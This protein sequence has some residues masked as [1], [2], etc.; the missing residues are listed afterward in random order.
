MTARKFTLYDCEANDGTKGWFVLKL[1]DGEHEGVEE[2][3]PYEDDPN[4]MYLYCSY[5]IGTACVEGT[6]AEFKA[7]SDAIRTG[8]SAEFRRCAA[9]RLEDGS[10]EI[11]S[12]R[13]E[14]EPYPVVSPEEA[15]NIVEAISE[16]IV[17]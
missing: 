11:Y 17:L 12:P 6:L 13:N 3:R 10:Y 16:R 5:R 7:I 14:R 8:E 1:A 4:A 9:T 2:L 15:L